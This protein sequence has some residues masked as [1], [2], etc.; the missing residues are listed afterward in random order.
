[1]L[2]GEKGLAVFFKFVGETFDETG[3]QDFQKYVLAGV[4]SKKTFILI[5]HNGER[6][7]YTAYFFPREKWRYELYRTLKLSLSQSGWNKEKENI[8]LILLDN[9]ANAT[10]S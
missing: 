5:D 6:L 3:G 2:D 9:R 8:E 1:M 10:L 7:K 4:I